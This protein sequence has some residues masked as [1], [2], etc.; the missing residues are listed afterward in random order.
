MSLESQY[1]PNRATD[2]GPR[3]DEFALSD[4]RNP[5][6]SAAAAKGA[7]AFLRLLKKNRQA[8]AAPA[9]EPRSH[10]AA[11][12]GGSAI[13]AA[14]G[15]SEGPVTSSTSRHTGASEAQ[16]RHSRP[17][18]ALAA[19]NAFMSVLNKK[20]KGKQRRGS[21][22]EW[23][24]GPL[25]KPG[26]HPQLK[27]AQTLLRSPTLLER[28]SPTVIS[29]RWEVDADFSC[30]GKPPVPVGARDGPFRSIVTTVNATSPSG[31]TLTAFAEEVAFF[32]A[33]DNEAR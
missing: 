31:R 24:A 1:G 23:P 28:A 19:A 32:Q 12:G 15:G 21:G 33:L 29:V 30:Y 13:A 18:A 4:P 17:A 26:G 10:A 8:A 16:H 20:A 9:D 6:A 7:K 27:W 22:P 14:A 11:G 3:G 25:H 2:D 5:Y